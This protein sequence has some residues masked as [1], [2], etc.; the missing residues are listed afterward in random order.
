MPTQGHECTATPPSVPE[1]EPIVS[2]TTI[3]I[4]AIVLVKG[5]D[6]NRFIYKANT[7]QFYKEDRKRCVILKIASAIDVC[8]KSLS[9]MELSFANELKTKVSITGTKANGMG[10][11]RI[12][13][14][15]FKAGGMPQASKS[16][17]ASV[18]RTT[19]TMQERIR[20]KRIGR[21]ILIK[22]GSE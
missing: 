4:T 18:S 12:Y 9:M 2:A 10:A 21:A 20:Q 14:E 19:E 3:A 6:N 15:V 7:D 8:I 5:D 13:T 22:I 16:D 17:K 11:G 1:R